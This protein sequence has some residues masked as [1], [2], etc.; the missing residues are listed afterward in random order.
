MLTLI[1]ALYGAFSVHALGFLGTY[2]HFQGPHFVDWRA[3]ATAGAVSMAAVPVFI[4]K[5]PMATLTLAATEAAAFAN[6]DRLVLLAALLAPHARSLK[7][8]TRRSEISR[9]VHEIFNHLA[10][11]LS[12]KHGLTQPV[13][14]AAPSNTPQPPS[15]ALNVDTRPQVHNFPNCN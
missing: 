9:V 2:R 15:G 12:A 11:D 6:E 10:I 1:V 3:L 7:Y 14:G 13:G 8:E 4:N 5:V